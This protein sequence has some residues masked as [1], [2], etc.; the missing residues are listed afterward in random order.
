MVTV[1]ATL[2]VEGVRHG[3]SQT[4]A[5][6]VVCD[7]KLLKTLLEA[8][9]SGCEA[10]QHVVTIGAVPADM[11]AK[12]PA[13]VKAISMDSVIAAGRDRPVPPSPP[14]PSDLAVI[15]YT[16]GTTGLPKGVMLSHA[17]VCAGMAGLKDAGKFTSSDVYLA[18]L[19]LAHI[20]ELTAE[21]VMFAIGCAVGY[22]SPQTLTDT[23]VKLAP[24][25]RGDAPTL[26]PTFMVF[27]PTVLDRV[28]QAVDAKLSAAHGLKG[29]LAAAAIALGFRDFE[30][31]K[32]G[33][34]PL[35]NAIVCKKI[36]ALVGG[37]VKLM[38]S[39]S[40]PLSKETQRF[41]QTVFN[42]PVRQGYG[43]T[44]TCSS[45]TVG[46]YDDND[47]NVGRVLSSCK[48]SLR[49]WEEGNYKN[50]DAENPAIRMPRGEILVGGPCVALGYYQ[51]ET[52]PDPE[53]AEKNA[54]DFITA[55]DG[56]RYF[57]TGDIG[58]FTSRGQCVPACGIAPCVPW[59]LGLRLACSD[60][61]AIPQ[62]ADH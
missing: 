46:A 48:V 28:R 49:D 54:T 52:S 25:T 47:W 26:R 62:A 32:I 45:A 44:E 58:Q 39:G 23:G 7:A 11:L 41:A 43:L 36:Q 34:P 9:S 15:M 18:Y 61:R 3:V 27:A 37:R 17:N 60:L 30:H 38:V 16:S 57:C 20:M 19:P 56:T 55:P 1:Y 21:C 31:G 14:K 51:S 53:I 8:A 29:K 10:L 5:R 22:G 4:A 42:C 13:G 33:A 12:L 59:I 50:S 35:L 6:V 24:G 2:G 40:A